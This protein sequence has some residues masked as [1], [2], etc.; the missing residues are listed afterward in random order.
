MEPACSGTPIITIRGLNKTFGAGDTAVT[1]LQ[2]IDLTIFEGEVFGIIGLSGA[3][4]STLVRCMNHL[5]KPTEGSVTIA[6]KALEA[7][8]GKELLLARRGMGMIFQQFNLLMQRTA[9]QNICFPLEISGVSRAEAK[10][11]ARELLQIVDLA[12]KE[13]AYPAQL[14]GG[15]KQRVAIARALAANPKVLLCDEATSALDPTTTRAI[16]DLLREI[17]QRLGITIVVITHEM[18][19]IEEICSRVAIIDNSRIA[20]IGSVRDIFLKPRT[21]IAKKLLYAS[22][23]LGESLMGQRCLRIVFDGTKTTSPVISNMVLECGAP[24]NILFADTK[25]I[26]GK[27]VGYTLVQLPDS[28]QIIEKMKKYLTLHEI[29]Y[30]EEAYHV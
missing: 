11:R 17:N 20:E 14:S 8:P 5:E 1:A 21:D 2:G 19:V 13:K 26:D 24:V 15:Q 29:T 12:D 27:M 18:S 25:T 4:K 7:L 22:G 6:G 30:Q 28:D 9:L 23:R 10:K 16:L 3:G